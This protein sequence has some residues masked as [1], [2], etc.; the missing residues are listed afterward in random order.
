M[1]L[2]GVSCSGKAFIFRLLVLLGHCF[3]DF[4]PVI[5]SLSKLVALKLSNLECRPHLDGSSSHQRLS[6]SAVFGQYFVQSDG[7]LSISGASASRASVSAALMN[8]TRI[9]A[10]EGEQGPVPLI[11]RHSPFK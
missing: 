9:T 8:L 6:F 10:L 3:A 7:E 1:R 2:E 4:S 11:P 5:V